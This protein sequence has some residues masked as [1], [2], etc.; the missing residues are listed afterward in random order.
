MLEH[1]ADKDLTRIRQNGIKNCSKLGPQGV[2]ALPA[3]LKAN[4]KPTS[5]AMTVA[6]LPVSFGSLG[7]L[8]FANVIAS[9]TI[10]SNVAGNPPSSSP[11]IHGIIVPGTSKNCVL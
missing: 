5:A 4:A 7:S 2:F 3:F 10:L 1:V 11:A 9:C 8:L 6:I